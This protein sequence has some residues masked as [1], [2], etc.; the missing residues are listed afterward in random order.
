MPRWIIT[1]SLKFRFLL[2]AA[3][4][5]LAVLPDHPA[6]LK[7]PLDVFFG[8]ALLEVEIQTEGPGDDCNGKKLFENESSSCLQR[9]RSRDSRQFLTARE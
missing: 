1:V 4:R 8:F 3:P 6:D 7:M 2:S 9:V 5:G